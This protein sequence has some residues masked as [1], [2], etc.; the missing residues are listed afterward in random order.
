MQRRKIWVSV[1]CKGLPY[2]PP[3]IMR[4]GLGKRR[5]CRSRKLSSKGMVIQSDPQN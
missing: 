5:P 3:R 4:S 1:M 2:P